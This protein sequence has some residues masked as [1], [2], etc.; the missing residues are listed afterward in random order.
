MK[1]GGTTN[2]KAGLFIPTM[3]VQPPA[4]LQLAPQLAT[5]VEV[6]SPPGLLEAGVVEGSDL[7]PGGRLSTFWQVWE[8][9]NAHPRVVTILKEGYCVNFRVKPPLTKYPVIRSKYLNRDKQQFLIKAVYQ[10]IRQ[11]SDNSSS[12]GLFPGILQSVV[13]CPQTRKE[14]ATSNRSECGKQLFAY[15]YFQDGN[16]RKYSRFASTR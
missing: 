1:I 10:M 8:A 16:C 9:K 12:K 3:K 13:S 4:P 14:M 15:S 6:L 5:E 11:K 2:P 7:V